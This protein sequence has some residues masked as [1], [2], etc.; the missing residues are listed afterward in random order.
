MEGASN[1]PLIDKFF[2]RGVNSVVGLPMD[3]ADNI[4]KQKLQTF[5]LSPEVALAAETLI[6]SKT[7][8]LPEVAELHM[9]YPHV[10]IEYPLTPDIMAL[11]D[12]GFNGTATIKRVGAYVHEVGDG[13]FV[14]MPYWEYISG[15]IEHSMFMFSF[16]DASGKQVV[17]IGPN[18]NGDGAVGAYLFP[19]WAFIRAAEKAG[20]TP[21]QVQKIVDHPST[22]QHIRESAVEIP[23]LMFASY[24]LLNCKSGVVKTSVAARTPPKGLKLGGRKQKAYSASAYTVLHLAAM[25]TVA[26]DGSISRRSD[27]SAH[28]VRGHFKQRRSGVYWWSSFVRGSG[29]PR[30]REA[31]LV[32]E[33]A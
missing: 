1:K 6:R 4:P 5:V 8:K 19:C 20:V 7:F 24:L 11:R 30:K 31:Y 32:E 28:Y 16:G 14:C 25:E 23:C 15:Q 26:S 27:I 12:L 18:P 9:P 10:A 17:S 22:I 29:E 13:S 33:T 21:A 2:Q 3:F